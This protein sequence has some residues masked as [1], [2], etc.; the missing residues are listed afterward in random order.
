MTLIIG[1][2]LYGEQRMLINDLEYFTTAANYKS[3]FSGIDQL[4]H[5]KNKLWYKIYPYQDFDYQFNSWG[6]RGAEYD[7]YI[8]NPVN[9]CLGDSYTVNVGGP[10]EHSWPSLL[11]KKYD[12][13]CLNLGM[14]GAGNDAIR[15]VYDRACKIFDVQKTFVVYSFLNRRLV[16]KKFHSD[17][18]D[19]RE[20]V[21]Y[22]KKQF[23]KDACFNFLPPW[24]WS[25]E[26]EHYI[27]IISSNYIDLEEN[28]W[29]ASMHRGI[30]SREDYEAKQGE[31]WC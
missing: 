31:E 25:A 9:L 30:V 23:I 28:Y 22:F 7:Q 2:T 5:A 24:C 17:Y 3:K 15:L 12:I 11:Q 16:N 26:E 10:I 14:D 27:G 20:N 29:D 19:F 13:P 21:E 1:C 6:F 8:G 18:H 4:K